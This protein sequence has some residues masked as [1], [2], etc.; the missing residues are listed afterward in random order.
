MMDLFEKETGLPR[1]DVD[2]TFFVRPRRHPFIN[3][4]ELE[5]DNI[6][7]AEVAYSKMKEG[8]RTLYFEI[9]KQRWKTKHSDADE[10]WY[11]V[12]CKDGCDKVED[13]PAYW[14]D[15]DVGMNS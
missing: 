13:V 6:T 7:A 4:P 9:K 15:E 3:E 1:S 12:L 2:I 14:G 11:S 8:T 5:F 10:F